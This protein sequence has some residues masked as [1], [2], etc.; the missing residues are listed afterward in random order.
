MKN[1]D[2][3]TYKYTNRMHINKTKRLKYQRLIKN[4]KDDKGISEIENELSEYNSKTCNLEK[5]IE[6]INKKNIR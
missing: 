5:F 4:Y 3:I 2:G 1:K 6:Y